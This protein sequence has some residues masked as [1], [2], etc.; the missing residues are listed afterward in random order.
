MIDR[1]INIESNQEI[2]HRWNKTIIA[3][4]KY[5]PKTSEVLMWLCRA[6]EELRWWL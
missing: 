6:D 2:K 5:L 4:S 3:N 1:A